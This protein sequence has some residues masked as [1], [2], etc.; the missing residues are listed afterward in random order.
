[1]D[2]IVEPDDGG[3]VFADRLILIRVRE[4]QMRGSDL[5]EP[6]VVFRRRDGQEQK[7]PLF[8]AARHLL[9]GDAVRGGGKAIHVLHQEVAA[10][11]HV[12]DLESQRLGRGGDVLIVADIFRQVVGKRLGLRGGARGCQNQSRQ[13]KRFQKPHVMASRL[14]LVVKRP[15]I[16]SVVGAGSKDDRLDNSCIFWVTAGA[17]LDRMPSIRP[18][19]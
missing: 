8:M 17:G 13:N 11:M 1:M 2:R 7:R 18:D 5:V 6:R 12:A 15:A 10:H 19:K 9:D 14:I 3:H 4:G 16:I